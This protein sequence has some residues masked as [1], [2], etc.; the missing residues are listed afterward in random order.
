MAAPQVLQ[1]TDSICFGVS[2]F[3]F[4]PQDA[5]LLSK[6]DVHYCTFSNTSFKAAVS[7]V[8][9]TALFQNCEQNFGLKVHS[10]LLNI[11]HHD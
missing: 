1:G 9:P 8:G 5:T 10:S 7:I 11:V 3:V 4:T 2:S 6:K